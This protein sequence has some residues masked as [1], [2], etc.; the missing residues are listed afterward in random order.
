MT[1]MIVV[2]KG[3][4]IVQFKIEAPDVRQAYVEAE[5][6]RRELFGDEDTSLNV[7]EINPGSQSTM[8][9]APGF[10]RA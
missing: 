7:I 10:P 1:F 8:G 4:D 2:K 3:K 5:N 6:K 9:M